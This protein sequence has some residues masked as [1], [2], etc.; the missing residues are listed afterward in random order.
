MQRPVGHDLERLLEALEVLG[1]DEHRGRLSVAGDDHAIL[2][3]RDAI[4][5]LRE[6]GLDGPERQSLGHDQS[7]SHQAAPGEPNPCYRIREWIRS[8]SQSR[9]PEAG[10]GYAQLLPDPAGACVARE[11]HGERRNRSGQTVGVHRGSAH[12]LKRSAGA[13]THPPRYT[14]GMS[15]QPPVERYG[16]L[17]L[18]RVTKDDGRAL[19]L[20]SHAGA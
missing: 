17:A 20:F 16:P 2:L 12:A 1:A 15:A 14:S 3:A 8:H 5:E 9:P 19:I 7:H 13:R 4:D 6:P 18:V 11:L 10:D